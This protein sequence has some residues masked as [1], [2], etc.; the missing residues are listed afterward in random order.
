MTMN[1]TSDKGVNHH[2][3]SGSSHYLVSIELELVDSPAQL[4]KC[5]PQRPQLQRETSPDCL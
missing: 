2:P 3:S 4:V 5:S 1:M